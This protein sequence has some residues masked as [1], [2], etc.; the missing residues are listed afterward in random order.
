MTTVRDDNKIP[1]ST[2]DA[3]GLACPLPLLKAKQG[4]R[5][6][7]LGEVLE[8]LATDAGSWRDFHAFA[9]QAGHGLLVAEDCGDSYRYLIQRGEIQ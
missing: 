7:V 5:H 4:L 3:R 1:V 2:V 6:L 8:V 9:Q